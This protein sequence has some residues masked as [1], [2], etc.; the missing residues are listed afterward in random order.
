MT[1]AARRVDRIRRARAT[2]SAHGLGSHRSYP[3]VHL[4]WHCLSCSHGSRIWVPSLSRREEFRLDGCKANRQSMRSR[5]FS[6]LWRHG[7]CRGSRNAHSRRTQFRYPRRSQSDFGEAWSGAGRWIPPSCSYCAHRATFE[8]TPWR[9]P[10]TQSSLGS[11]PG[12]SFP[13]GVVERRVSSSRGSRRIRFWPA[14]LFFSAVFGR[15]SGQSW[16]KRAGHS[17]SG[18]DRFTFLPHDPANG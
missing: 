5:H 7:L 18:C 11:R 13:G 16:R 1:S 3:A 6:P 8:L 2:R 9:S 15:S 14:A 10:E 17:A 12:H 4:G